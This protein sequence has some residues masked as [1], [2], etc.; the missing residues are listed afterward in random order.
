MLVVGT[1]TRETIEKYYPSVTLTS[2][3]TRNALQFKLF[4]ARA[5][6][7]IFS[8]C[9]FDSGAIRTLQFVT[10]PTQTQKMHC[11]KAEGQGGT[12]Y[13]RLGEQVDQDW[14]NRSGLL[15]S[16]GIKKNRKNP[17]AEAS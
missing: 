4:W 9:I 8:H 12:G 7:N 5:Q 14:G 3:G 13:Q 17:P 10:C 11:K 16:P 15:C 1:A 6:E 2:S